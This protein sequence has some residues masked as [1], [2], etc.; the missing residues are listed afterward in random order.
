M[1]KLLTVLALVLAF[2][3]PAV[4]QTAEPQV[5]NPGAVEFEPS[6]DHALVGAYELDILRP[7]GSVLQTI[8]LGKPSP[9]EGICRSAINVQPVA[10]GK[11]Y[12]VRLRALAGSAASDYALSLNKFERAPGSPSKV[13][14]K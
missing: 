12:S 9:I 13:V 11:D 5:K 3:A 2:A 6:A 7:D 8:N 1:K 10:F 14:A 4:A